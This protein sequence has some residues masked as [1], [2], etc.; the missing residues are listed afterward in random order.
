M[1]CKKQS[2]VDAV[3]FCA[4]FILIVGV[5]I[6]FLNYQQK[7]TDDDEQFMEAVASLGTGVVEVGEIEPE[8]MFCYSDL[9]SH[10][11]SFQDSCVFYA[12]IYANDYISPAEILAM[13]FTESGFDRDAK[14]GIGEIGLLQVLPSTAELYGFNGDSLGTPEY[15]IYVSTSIIKAEGDRRVDLIGLLPATFH[16]FA[17]YATGNPQSLATA[18]KYR[19]LLHERARRWVWL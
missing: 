5:V 14:G 15:N 10:C 16:S 13:I 4:A 8:I 19:S 12:V 18:W 6:L 7:Q 17:A 1:K 2:L 3:W 11:R 9:I